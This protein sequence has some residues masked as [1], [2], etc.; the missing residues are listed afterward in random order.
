[1]C[2]CMCR[3]WRC[4]GCTCSTPSQVLDLRC[5]EFVQRDVLA[6]YGIDGTVLMEAARVSAQQLAHQL[7]DVNL[8]HASPH[9]VCAPWEEGAQGWCAKAATVLEGMRRAVASDA[10]A[11][12]TLSLEYAVRDAA[13]D[14]WHRGEGPLACVTLGGRMKRLLWCTR[15][16]ACCAPR[17]TRAAPRVPARPKSVEFVGLGDVEAADGGPVFELG[18]PLAEAPPAPSPPARKRQAAPV[19]PV[20]QQ[21]DVIAVQRDLLLLSHQLSREFYEESRAFAHYLLLLRVIGEALR[22]SETLLL[23]QFL[24][25]A[26][27][28][29][30]SMGVTV[31]AHVYGANGYGA[32]RMAALAA[33]LQDLPAPGRQRFHALLHSYV[34]DAQSAYAQH[35]R[36]DAVTA[37]DA[38]RVLVSVRAR[39][40]VM[41]QR[42]I[43]D[44]RHRAAER[45]RLQ[46]ELP[47]DVSEAEQN[48]KEFLEVCAH[49]ALALLGGGGGGGV[50]VIARACAGRGSEVQV[51]QTGQLRSRGAVR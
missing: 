37:E 40:R 48:D 42:R 33:W 23:Q 8:A 20:V 29:L 10:S 47:A 14:A 19:T 41:L 7:T 27:G 2:V 28:N 50:N 32:V 4:R 39:E 1:M 45:E 46:I 5:D 21:V 36:D 15:T 11:R 3:Q 18:G 13:C 17:R 51:L 22:R 12:T 44:F 31:P 24:R 16:W 43:E 25:E 9:P 38:G 35:V 6:G 34:S 26:K 30:A 49:P